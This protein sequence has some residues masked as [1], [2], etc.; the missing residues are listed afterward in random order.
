VNNEGTRNVLHEALRAGAQRILLAST[1]S[2][3][4]CTKSSDQPAKELRLSDEN[5]IAP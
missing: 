4:A 3:L 1:E 2:I 5:M